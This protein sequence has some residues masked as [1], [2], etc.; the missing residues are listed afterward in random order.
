MI[1]KVHK[2]ITRNNSICFVINTEGEQD[3]WYWEISIG[4][5]DNYWK[6]KNPDCLNGN[7]MEW[8]AN[9]FVNSDECSHCGCSVSSFLTVEDAIKDYL[10]G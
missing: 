10:A 8:S 9:E 6:D 3:F 7:V 2:I 4:T 1:N 5:W